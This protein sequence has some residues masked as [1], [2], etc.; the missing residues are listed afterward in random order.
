MS[1]A[2]HEEVIRY[3]EE[4]DWD[5]RNVWHKGMFQAAHFGIYDHVATRHEAAL[6][7]TTKIMAELAGVQPGTVMMDAGCGWGGTSLW[8]AKHQ[9][10]HVTGVNIAS[11]QV[12]ECRHKADRLGVS[13]HCQF[14]ESDYC[15]TPFADESFEVIWSCESLCHAPDKSALYQEASRLLKPGGRLV[16][17][18]YLRTARPVQNESLL[19]TWLNGWACTDIDTAEEHHHHAVQAGFRSCD[20]HDYSTQV[21]TSLHNLYVHA[22]RWRWIG[23]LGDKM[24]LLKPYRLKN[25]HGTRAM[26]ESFMAGLWRYQLILATK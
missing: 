26:Y 22:K 21:K 5:H 7:N 10:V 15:S 16:I 19:Q 23:V 6:M 20:M 9:K 18:D 12:R 4:T 17:A 8:L 24:R 13:E 14:V 11:Y 3:Y 25:V 1:R 2:H